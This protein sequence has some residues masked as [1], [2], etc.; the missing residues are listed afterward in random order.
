MTFQLPAT[1]PSLGYNRTMGRLSHKAI[2]TSALAMLAVAALVPTARCSTRAEG[3][4]LRD[5]KSLDE[6]REAFNRDA[7]K[8][9]LVLLLSPT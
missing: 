7:G 3:S 6:L 2:V 4:P 5:L 8:P 1:S 9:R